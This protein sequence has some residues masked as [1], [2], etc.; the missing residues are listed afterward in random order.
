M[1]LKKKLR[2]KK[3]S[4]GSW[5]TIG[6]NT[7]AEIMSKAGFDWLAIDMEH[8]ALSA[9]QCQELVR[10]IDLCQ[11]PALVRV[12]ANDPLL[13]KRAMDAGAVGVI[14]PMVNS[15][16]DAKR[17]VKA[18]KYPPKGS[19][20]VG[21]SRA[22]G[23]GTSFHEYKKWLEAESV[24]IAQIEHIDGVNNLAEIMEVEG[25]DALMVGPYD[26]SGSLGIPGNFEDPK[27]L[28]ALEKIQRSALKKKM[29]LGYHVVSSDPKLVEKKIKEGYTFIAFGVDFL[30]L[31][32][33]C[34]SGLRVLNDKR[35]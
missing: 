9:A 4:I 33:N 26:L 22:Q 31:G 17:A 28:Q 18:V 24:V 19:R 32:D 27:M 21:L 20:G 11:V 6:D 12:G 23:Y 2:N 30:F 15:P 34:R 25:I 29:P 10:V 14:V 1:T 13:I 16:E 7:I 8:S 5:I 35:I 3:L